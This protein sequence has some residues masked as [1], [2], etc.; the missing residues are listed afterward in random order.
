[1]ADERTPRDLESRDTEAREQTWKPPQILPDP[2]P[3]PD[4][5]FKYVRVSVH[6]VADSVN[7]SQ[8]LREGWV[9]VKASD[10]PEISFIA[11]K[12][13]QW[14]D[15]IEI[16][17][18]LLC[19]MPKK[20]YEQRS[21][22]YRKLAEAQLQSIDHNFLRESHPAMP[23]LKPERHTRVQFGRPKG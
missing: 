7:I 11:D 9:P 19:K 1:M 16:G 5:E 15:G 13:S 2:T 8:H 18:L 20:M 14:K 6:G 22:H 4:W 17:G 3:S 21:A 10:H 12:K 23:L